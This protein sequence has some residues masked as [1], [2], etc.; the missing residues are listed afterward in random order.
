MTS[1]ISPSFN[2]K[3]AV[4]TSAGTVVEVESNLT[5]PPSSAVAVSVDFS[6]L[7]Y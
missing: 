3:A 6:L 1:E 2:A 7:I 4:C 5:V